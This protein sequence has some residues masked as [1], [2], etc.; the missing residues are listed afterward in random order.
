[1]LIQVLKEHHVF[2]TAVPVYGAG[3]VMRTGMLER[4]KIYVPKEEKAKAEELL[5]ELFPEENA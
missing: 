4:L 2:Y 1:M 3:L 5:A